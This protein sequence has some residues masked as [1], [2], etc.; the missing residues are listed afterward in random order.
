MSTGIFIS[1]EVVYQAFNWAILLGNTDILAEVIEAFEH[2][3]Q[4]RLSH[5]VAW[6]RLQIL[7]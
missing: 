6:Q 5:K 3:L 7:C 4:Q 1:D 2:Q